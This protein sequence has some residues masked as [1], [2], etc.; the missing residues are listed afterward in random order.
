MFRRGRYE[1]SRAILAL[2]LF[3]LALVLAFEV[4]ATVVEDSPTEV[5]CERIDLDTS[6]RHRIAREVAGELDIEGQ[7]GE[8]VW[9]LVS[10]EMSRVCARSDPSHRPVNSD[11]RG[12]ILQRLRR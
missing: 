6:T 7:P 5:T 11:L 1:L 10:E 9:R 4:A 12:T 3:M 8:P 2:T